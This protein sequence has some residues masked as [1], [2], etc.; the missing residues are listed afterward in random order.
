MISLEEARLVPH[1]APLGVVPPLV[2]ASAVALRLSR[3]KLCHEIL[4]C[5]PP[6]SGLPFEPVTKIPQ[7]ML[8]R[9]QQRL[10]RRRAPGAAN[11]M[12]VHPLVVPRL[13]RDEDAGAAVGVAS[14]LVLMKGVD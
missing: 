9:H 4:G 7:P 13:P 5:D 2:R 8:E 12:D 14:V 1:H 6:G 10:G 3:L 11:D